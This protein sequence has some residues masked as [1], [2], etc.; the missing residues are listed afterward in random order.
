[1]GA[2]AAK[3]DNRNFK[4]S[5]S[6]HVECDFLSVR[7]PIGLGAITVA[8]RN[9]LAVPATGRN[10]VKL[11]TAAVIKRINNFL[12]VRRPGWARLDT[13]GASQPSRTAAAGADGVKFRITVFADAE[14]NT[15][16]IRRK[17]RATV[18]SR[19][20]DDAIARAARQIDY[21][22]IRVTALITGVGDSASIR[23]DRWMHTNHAVVRKLA[24]V[25]AVVI[26]HINFLFAAARGNKRNFA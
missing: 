18:C 16:P 17:R 3:I 24:D 23:A 15:A 21:V 2:A 8:G 26:A 9:R 22:N 11:R 25:R 12:A 1:M 6:A 7:R 5:A 14:R 19:K 13:A 10:P 4:S 20:V